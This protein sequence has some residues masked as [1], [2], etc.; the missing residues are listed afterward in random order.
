MDLYPEIEPYDHGMLDVGDGN[1]VYWEACGNPEGKPALVVHGGPGSG[2]SAAF[3]RLFNPATYRIVLFDQRNCGRSHPHACHPA[4]DLAS[5]DTQHLVADIEL[6]RSRLGIER[7]LVLGG[8]WGSTLSLAY[9]ESHPDRVT[10]MVL[11]GVTTGRRSELN[12]LFRGGVAMFFPEQ[13]DRLRMAVPPAYQGP[14]IVDAYS[15][16]LNDADA[17]ARKTAAEE[18]CRWESATPHWPPTSGL[19]DR[20]RDPDFAL[21]FARIVTRYVKHNLWLEDGVLLRN[22]HSL[23]N[24]PCAL[25]NGRYDFQSPIGSAWELRRELPHASLVIVDEVGHSTSKINREL[26]RAT[27]RFSHAGPAPISP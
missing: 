17:N 24:I 3:R 27:D 2:S 14:D 6:M 13:W 7:W 9:A 21:A 1:T 12:W 16:W 18:W 4:T 11:F 25:V 20:F 19:D 8:S 22:A 10:E 23:A 5:N 15:R 26:V